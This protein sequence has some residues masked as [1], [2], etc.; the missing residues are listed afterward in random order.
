MVMMVT[1]I[2]LCHGGLLVDSDNGGEKMRIAFFMMEIAVNT[3][4]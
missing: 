4:V 3:S 2:S 1:E